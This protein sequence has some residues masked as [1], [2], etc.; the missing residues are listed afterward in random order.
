MG[1]V[2]DSTRIRS[3]GAT[4]KQQAQDF[5]A[6]YNEIK[7]TIRNMIPFPGSSSAWIWYN[8]FILLSPSSFEA[9]KLALN[10]YSDFLTASAVQF[11]NTE[12][13]IGSETS[14]LRT[15]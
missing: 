2:V 15:D 10:E 12:A 9:Y 11:E 14:T 6:L 13:K 3:A 1:I 8:Q 7:N 4:I 5:E